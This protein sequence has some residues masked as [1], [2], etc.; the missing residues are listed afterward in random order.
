M[1]NFQADLP[2]TPIF[3]QTDLCCNSDPGV[4]IVQLL[5]SVTVACVGLGTTCAGEK[6]KRC[7]YIKEVIPSSD[8]IELK[9]AL[10]AVF[11]RFGTAEDVVVGTSGRND[12]HVFFKT[13]AS[14][15]CGALFVHL[16][17]LL[18][19]IAKCTIAAWA[20]AARPVTLLLHSI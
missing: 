14:A 11:Q 9:T 5:L 3:A 8:K 10:R 4:P 17:H 13:A 16:L 15:V 19:A 6:G 2:A 12:A 18:V 20:A 7:V 1:T